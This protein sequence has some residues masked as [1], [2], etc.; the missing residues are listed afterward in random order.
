MTPFAEHVGEELSLAALP[1]H[2]KWQRNAWQGTIHSF[3]RLRILFACGLFYQPVAHLL[4][5]LSNSSARVYNGRVMGKSCIPTFYGFIISF[6][7]MIRA[8]R[9]WPI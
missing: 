4:I 5:S 2:E 9:I 3:R 1:G 8:N 7:N 6:A